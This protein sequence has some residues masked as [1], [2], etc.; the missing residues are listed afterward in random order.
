MGNSKNY[1]H[2]PTLWEG[3]SLNREHVHIIDERP[4]WDIK[5][6]NDGEFKNYSHPLPGR[7][8]H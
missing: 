7:G 4:N 2:P 1:S 5:V 8:N 6:W 3:K